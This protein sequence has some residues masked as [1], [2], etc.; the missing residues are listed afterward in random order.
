MNHPYL[1]LPCLL[2]LTA[3]APLSA[4][5][6]PVYQTTDPT[7]QVSY[8]DTPSP[9][10]TEVRLPPAPDPASVEQAE[11]IDQRLQQQV[12]PDAVTLEHI[13]QQRRADRQRLADE[14]AKQHQAEAA[15]REQQRRHDFYIENGYWPKERP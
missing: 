14:Q 8:S 15:R 1:M 4:A 10:A 2:C 7:G 3:A 9:G 11:A 6:D 12:E 13:E 5:P